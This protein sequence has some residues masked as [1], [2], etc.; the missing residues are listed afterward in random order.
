MGPDGSANQIQ[1]VGGGT[2]VALHRN[3]RWLATVEAREE[4]PIGTGNPGDSRH[5]G[6]SLHGET[7]PYLLGGAA[8]L[9]ER[10]AVQEQP[11]PPV[12]NALLCGSLA[13]KVILYRLA[14]V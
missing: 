5:S 14:S 6:A 2:L 3:V 8:T 10:L 7:I 11:S 13:K 9:A 1:L 4:E 12:G